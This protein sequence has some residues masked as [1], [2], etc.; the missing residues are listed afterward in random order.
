MEPAA[1]SAAFMCSIT[2]A[3]G[4]APAAAAAAEAD[5][6]SPSIQ[7]VSSAVSALMLRRSLSGSRGAW[8]CFTRALKRCRAGGEEAGALVGK[9]GSGERGKTHYSRRWMS[10]AAP[11]VHA[12]EAGRHVRPGAHGSKP[13]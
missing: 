3:R 9:R 4:G 1:E 13:S 8:K 11:A 5:P 10:V 7:L 12:V 2:S 6:S